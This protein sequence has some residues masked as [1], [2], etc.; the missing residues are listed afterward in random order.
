[1]QFIWATILSTFGQL[2]GSLGVL[3]GTLRF[4]FDHLHSQT[5]P[6]YSCLACKCSS[7]LYGRAWEY[8]LL[9]LP[10]FSPYNNQITLSHNSARHG[11]SRCREPCVFAIAMFSRQSILIPPVPAP[12]PPAGARR[13]SPWHGTAQWQRTTRRV[14]T[15]AG[16]SWYTRCRDRDSN[17]PGAGACQAPRPRRGPGGNGSRP[18]QPQEERN[19]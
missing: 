15:P 10:R 6:C 8:D 11:P 7:T 12:P 16:L 5:S 1:M 14:P 13:S 3:R 9:T 19:A 18:A 17:G 2:Q 4:H